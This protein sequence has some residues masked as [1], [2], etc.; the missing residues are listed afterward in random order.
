MKLGH[1]QENAEQDKP[2]GGRNPSYSGGR[3]QEDCSPRPAGQI[4]P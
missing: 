1:L 2:A 3:D 4:V